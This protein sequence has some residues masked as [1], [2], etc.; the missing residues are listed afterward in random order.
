MLRT[1]HGVL[2]LSTF[3]LADTLVR[4]GFFLEEPLPVEGEWRL[5]LADRERARLSDG[6][7]LRED[8]TALLLEDDLAFE[9]AALT[10][11]S[12]GY[13]TDLDVAFLSMAAELGLLLRALLLEAEGAT[14]VRCGAG[15][16]SCLIQN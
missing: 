8:P 1:P 5:R 3:F 12:Y 7:L 14:M 16:I 10:E 2:G 15:P 6:V 11:R 4:S 13:L 9:V